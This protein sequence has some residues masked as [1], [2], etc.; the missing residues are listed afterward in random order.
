MFASCCGPRGKRAGRQK[1][2]RQRSSRAPHS[3]AGAGVHSA[4]ARAFHHATSNGTSG[5]AHI[6]AA[7]IAACGWCDWLGAPPWLRQ[8]KPPLRPLPAQPALP[9]HA[10]DGWEECQE[11]FS[12]DGGEV[13][14]LASR[15]RLWT[16]ASGGRAGSSRAAAHRTRRWLSPQLFLRGAAGRRPQAEAHR[17]PG[18]ET[19]QPCPGS[20]SSHA[21]AAAA[22]AA[23]S[24]AC[25]DRAPS[26]DQARPALPAHADEAQRGQGRRAPWQPAASRLSAQAA[27]PLR[28]IRHPA[29][30]LHQPR[31]H[32]LA[33]PQG[34]GP[35]R[36]ARP[37]L[38]TRLP[39]RPPTDPARA[40]QD[41]PGA[42]SGR[43]DYADA[44][45][46]EAQDDS[47]LMMRLAG[48]LT[49]LERTSTAG[50]PPALPLPG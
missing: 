4:S 45:Q 7:A 24:D 36:C 6:R 30:A 37:G 32:A 40:P 41:H 14:R 20:S 28:A 1:T 33:R 43:T 11:D 3:P 47:G 18:G 17:A 49:M 9:L 2:K 34:P 26:S 35:S 10:D 22:A 8:Q 39:A 46:A 5:G 50:A 25:T 13:P 44:E 42:F 23:A 16:P 31:A 12:V 19:R 29:R 21:A 48:C 15:S 38:P 27:R